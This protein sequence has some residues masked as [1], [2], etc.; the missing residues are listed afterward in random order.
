MAAVGTSLGS[1]SVDHAILS[2]LIAEFDAELN[3]KTGQWRGYCDFIVVQH[4]PNNASISCETGKL[5]TDPH[6][7]MPMTLPRDG[8]VSLM[9]QKGGALQTDPCV[10]IMACV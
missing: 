2:A 3:A 10:I 9:T 7:W 4:S 6:F 8:Y 1:F 5:D